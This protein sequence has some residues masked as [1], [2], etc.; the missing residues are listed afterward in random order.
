M[1]R[2]NEVLFF[3]LSVKSRNVISHILFMLFDLR[4]PQSSTGVTYVQNGREVG[5][6]HLFNLL[7]KGA[8]LA[9]KII[10]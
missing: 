10:L 4:M 7:C 8:Y 5:F 9:V 1:L 6:C 2:H 3:I